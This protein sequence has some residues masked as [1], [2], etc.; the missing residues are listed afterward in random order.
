M[1][2]TLPA[3]LFVNHDA[4]K[5]VVDNP[6]ILN[7]SLFLIFTFLT[8]ITFRRTVNDRP[9]SILQ[10]NQMKGLAIIIVIVHHLS[11][12]T[13]ENSSDLIIFRDSGFLGVALFLV[14]SG[15]GLSLS[16]QKKGIKNFFTK[17]LTKVYVPFLFA[18]LLE[19]FLNKLIFNKDNNI[20][21]KLF[22]IFFNVMLIDRNMWFIV[23]IILWYGITYL[24]FWL[25]LSNLLKICFLC[26]VSLGMLLVPQI[27]EVWKFN[28][29][30][31]PLGCWLGLN[32]K[33]I[34]PKIESL[35]NQKIGILCCIIIG[36][37]ILTI[38]DLRFAYWAYPHHQLGDNLLFSITTIIFLVY[39][40]YKKATLPIY[41]ESISG[42]LA[43]AIVGLNYFSMSSYNYNITAIFIKNISG[44]CCAFTIFLLVSLMLKYNLYSAFLS[45]IGDISFELYLLHG[46]FMYSFDFILFRGNISVMFF[47]YFILIFLISIIF[48][49]FNSIVYNSILNKL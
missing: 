8:L 5:I 26:S 16:L 33:F 13:I 19:V 12:H 21:N 20:F 46:M 47:I 37:S 15:F 39:L 7:L 32:Y 17:R 2:D 40:A 30:S 38:I 9:L 29:F 24:I 48:K 44:I 22:N 49:K 27:I 4:T 6:I 43:L 23:F 11:Y 35:I 3:V 34:L 28:A 10:T 14:L 1:L 45:V 36:F 25:N 41:I 18:M 31:F 42:L